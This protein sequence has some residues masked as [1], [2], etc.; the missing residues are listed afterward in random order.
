MTIQ[1][2]ELMIRCAC[3]LSPLV[4]INLDKS[5]VYS[6]FISIKKVMVYEMKTI[7]FKLHA[8]SFRRL[9]VNIKDNI[10]L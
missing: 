8:S 9:W 1:C 5:I 10:T 4:Y 2:L 7:I 6:L 3:L